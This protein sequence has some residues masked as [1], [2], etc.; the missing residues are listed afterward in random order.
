VRV[1][2]EA[3][4]HREAGEGRAAPRDGRVEH[5]QARRGPD[6]ALPGPDRLPVAKRWSRGHADSQQ[7]LRRRFAAPV[8]AAVTCQEI[9]VAHTQAIVNAAPAA[10]EGDRLHRMLSAMVGAGIKGGYLASPL[11]AEA[12]WQAGDRLLPAPA[13]TTA[14]ESPLWVDPAEIPAGADV[15]RLGRAL[16]AG[17]GGDR[18]ELMASLAACSGLRWG[19]LA[20]LTIAQ[21]ALAARVITVDR[22]GGRGGRA[23]VCGGPEEP[24]VPQHRLPPPHSRRL[25]ARRAARRQADQG[26]QAGGPTWKSTGPRGPGGPAAT[27]SAAAIG[28][29]GDVDAAAVA[30]YRASVREGRPLSERRLAAACGKTSRRWARNRMAEARHSPATA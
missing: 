24:Q 7:R 23:P 14:G 15:A 12:R 10:G 21:V 29:A 2:L 16:A 1:R 20:A 28:S 27:G 8:I 11:L 17:R 22:K 25:P 30:A 26:N 6:R 19:E 5:D 18:D 13:V 9:T 3:G 4:V